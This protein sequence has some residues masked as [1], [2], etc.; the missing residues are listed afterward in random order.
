MRTAGTGSSASGERLPAKVRRWSRRHPRSAWVI[1]CLLLLADVATGQERHLRFRHI[2]L[3]DGLPSATVH[4]TLQDRDGFIWLATPDGLSRFDGYDFVT[5]RHIEDDPTSLRHNHVWCLL[6]DREG[7]L[8][9]GTDGGGLSRLDPASGSFTHF[10]HD[11][12]DLRSLSDDRVRVLFEDRAGNLWAGTNGGGL[13]RFEP[14]SSSF[15]RYRRIAGDPNSLS[16]DQVR[17]LAQDE[18]GRIWIGTDGGGLSVLDPETDSFSHYRHHPDDPR[19]LSSDRVRVVYLDGRATL[20]VGTYDAGLNRLDPSSKSFVRFEADDEVSSSLIDNTV[21]AILEDSKGTLWVGTDSGLDEWLPDRES[22]RHHVRD[23]A[24]PHS[25]THDRTTSLFEDRGGVLWVGT[26]AGLATW[27]TGAG[28]FFHYFRGAGESELLSDNYVTSFA[29]G[30]DGSIWVGT[31]RGLNKFDPGSR[32]F[33]HYR[34]AESE[35]ASLSDDRVMSLLVDSRGVLWA[36]TLS[37]GLNRFDSST[38]TF[39]RYVHD[40]ADPTTI[41]GN[42]VTSIV[43]D[44]EGSIWVG[45]YREGLNRLDR[46]TEVF[47]RF[48]HVDADPSSLS[49]D[50]VTSIHEDGDGALWIATEDRG[51]NRLDR[52][53]EA[54]IRYRHDPQDPRSLSGD[55]AFLVTGDEADNLWIGTRTSGLNLWRL[56]D[57]RQDHPVFRRY[58]TA[59]GLANPQV[60]A[61]VDDG[62]GD[63]W[64]TTNRGLSRL[65]LESDS[66]VNYDASDGLQSDEFNFAAAVR[67]S[68]GQLYLGGINGFNA[69]FP[70]RIRSNPHIPPVVLTDFLK[71]NTPTDLGRP[72][73][74]IDQVSLTYKDSVIAFRFAALD[75]T[76]PEKN[77][78]MYK[79]EGFDLSWVDARDMRQATYTNLHPGTYSFRVRGSNNDGVWNDDGLELALVV[80]PPPWLRWWAKLLY[81]IVLGSAL[82][83][84]WRAYGNKKRRARVLQRINASLKEEIRSGKAKERAL[85]AE[86][87]KAREYFDVAE[88]IMVALDDA[89]KVVMINQKGCRLLGRPEKEILGRDWLVEFVPRG[90]W[91]SVRAALFETVDAYH[92]YEYPLV[93]A[94]GEQRTISWHSNYLPAAEGEPPTILSSG[95]DNTDVRLL[96]RQVRMQQKMDALGTLAGGIAHDFNNI[97][98]ATLGYSNLTLSRLPPDSEEASFIRHVVSGCERASEM[99]ARILSFSRHEDSKKEP[100]AI[101]P[102]IEEVCGFVRSTIPPGIEIRTQVPS[103]C[104]PVDAVS[105]QIHQV[106]M[107]LATNAVHAM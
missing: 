35:P 33:E 57:R 101:G 12:S 70:T 55:D 69:F 50:R 104:L 42:A 56:A 43:E 52:D 105:T 45:V 36:G 58:S 93:T 46:E 67:A 38:E 92:Y 40:P 20:W 30:P 91:D 72:L 79:L 2:T 26:L 17:S 41:S 81:A 61:M 68:D 84:A 82:G 39:E 44:H 71:F 47:T 90:H 48:R 11:A 97:L 6:E 103:N 23:P 34:H 19:S 16:D 22:F 74:R 8:W 28:E 63:L 87:R 31:Q 99:V 77:R 65:N 4:A 98:T 96:E 59:D 86:K 94:N 95:V 51:I 78:Y 75:Y 3:K 29:E 85:E 32:R 89:G 106:L 60:L 14:D 107:N 7:R 83:T 5:Y 10:R 9:A 24:D 53:R 37:G 62:H 54:F 49:S 18:A 73:A 100:V 102:I 21:R 64:V 15:T 27:N 80:P 25:L 76:A 1:P 13:N 66:F 88:V